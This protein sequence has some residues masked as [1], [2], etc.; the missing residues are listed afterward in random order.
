MSNNDDKRTKNIYNRHFRNYSIPKICSTCNKLL[1]AD[2]IN[3]NVVISVR[4]N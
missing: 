3:Y 2:L 1:L 4:H